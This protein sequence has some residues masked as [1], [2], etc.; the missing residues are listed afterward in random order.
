MDRG[1]DRWGSS[2]HLERFLEPCTD[3]HWRTRK[4]RG[5]T[6]DAKRVTQSCFR[7]ISWRRACC[8]PW[9]ELSRWRTPE[10][11]SRRS[12]YIIFL[13]F[14]LTH[15]ILIC[16]FSMIFWI[17]RKHKTLTFLKQSSMYL[18]D[19]DQLLISLLN[20]LPINNWDILNVM[21][22]NADLVILET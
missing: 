19:F 8:V 5:L 9:I 15:M 10:K 18:L 16:Y 14:S 22:T 11:M 2:K 12:D 20:Y 3:T 7:R 4:V 21:V 17:F 1:D 6:R 13:S